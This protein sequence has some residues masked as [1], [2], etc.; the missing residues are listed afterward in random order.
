[1]DIFINNKRVSNEEVDAWEF[2][3]LK[4]QYQFFMKRGYDLTNPSEA[5]NIKLARKDMGRFKASIKPEQLRRILKNRYKIGNLISKM[6][7]L[8]S[9]GKR[10]YSM[11]EFFIPT[12]LSPERVMD[13]I[14][15]IMLENT[16]EHLFMN[17]ATNPDHFV[18]L[19]IGDNIQEVVEM[20]G[21]SPL[22]T[23]F[24]AHY[25]DESGLTS[26]RSEG[27]LVQLAGCAKLEDGT[28]IGGV[29]HQIKREENGIRFKALVE[30]PSMVPK[31]MLNKHQYHLACEFREWLGYIIK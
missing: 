1:M 10:R 27:Y 14:K 26:S 31:F 28:V 19:G 4:Y 12:T 5:P 23:R 8:L 16:Q 11:T 2:K 21:G 17:L 20:T 25:G 29:R 9:R 15:K 30:F 22:P 3:R 18:L 13:D 6:T 7:A 24:F